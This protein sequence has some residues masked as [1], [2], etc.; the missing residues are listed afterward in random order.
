M[1][2]E[3]PYC[4]E[5]KLKHPRS[6][7]MQ[8]II[9]DWYIIKILEPKT[10]ALLGQILWGTVVIDETNR[11]NS[12]DYIS[13]SLIKDINLEAKLV[14][15]QSNSEYKLEGNWNEFSVYYSEVKLL[16]RG[17]SPDQIIQ[18]RRSEASSRKH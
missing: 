12:G 18:I 2:L 3:R 1:S 6:I 4:K 9:K 11:F 16:D 10:E 17:F 5:G 8:T 7:C 13:S 15:T 14:V